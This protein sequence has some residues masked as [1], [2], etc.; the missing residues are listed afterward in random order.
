MIFTYMQRINSIFVIMLMYNGDKY[1]EYIIFS[2][3]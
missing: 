1:E 2:L 3:R